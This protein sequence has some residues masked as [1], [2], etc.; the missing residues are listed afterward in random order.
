MEAWFLADKD[1]LG[2]F[3]GDGFYRGAL[4]ARSD[5]ENVTK[6]EVL[7]GLKAATR[8]C[9]KKGEYGKGRHSFDILAQID[10]VKVTE[11]SLQAKRLV[12]TLIQKMEA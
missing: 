7:N 5:V 2:L 1:T 4:P 6:T 11:A 9:K 8:R 12:E 10:P 3:F